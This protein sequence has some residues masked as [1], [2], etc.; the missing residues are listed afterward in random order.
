MALPDP[1][2]PAQVVGGDDRHGDGEA[3]D[4][5]GLH[6]DGH[7]L[8]DVGPVAR[9]AGLCMLGWLFVHVCVWG[10]ITLDNNVKNKQTPVRT[11]ARTSAM[12][13][14]GW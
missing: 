1:R 13:R 5:G 3:G 4:D 10:G 11:Y 6:P 14:T 8:D 2:G 7:A 12:E 9:R